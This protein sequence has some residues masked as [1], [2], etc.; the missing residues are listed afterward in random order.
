MKRATRRI[1]HHPKM[2]VLPLEGTAC[3]A[4]KAR[5]HPTHW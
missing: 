2:G 1:E 5:T 4:Q 3:A